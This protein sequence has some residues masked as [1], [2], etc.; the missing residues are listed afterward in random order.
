MKALL[1]LLATLQTQL[2][3]LTDLQASYDL[4]VKAAHDAGVLEGVASVIIDPAKIFTQADLDKAVSDAVAALGNGSV[5]PSSDKIFS[6]A[7]M[8]AAIVQ[9]KAS[10]LAKIKLEEVNLEK[11]AE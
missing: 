11:V 6:Q 4:D 7:E 8:D 5:S 2:A 1:E 10:I 9:V 3:M